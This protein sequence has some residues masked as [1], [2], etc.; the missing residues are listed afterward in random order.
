MLHPDRALA[1]R[2]ANT[3]LNIV[4]ANPPGGERWSWF[5][6]RYGVL[7][8]R[9][10]TGNFA[11][12][13]RLRVVDAPN[14]EQPPSG[15][16]NAGGFVIRNPAG[17]HQGD[18]NW[19]MY[20]IGAQG[21]SGYAREVKKT[22]GSRSG[23]YLN[24]QPFEGA[25]LLVCRVD[26]SFRF[27]HWADGA[28]QAERVIPDVTDIQARQWPEV[29]E[30]GATPIQFDLPGL[31][32]TLQMGLMTGAW[33]TAGANDMTRT[34]SFFDYVRV[35]QVAPQDFTDCPLAFANP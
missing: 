21:P 13:A 16:F 34:Q 8:Y 32:A 2:I 4:A 14:A 35:A 15:A 19:V 30:T 33:Q 17:T 28:W 1:V 3:R 6:D 23:L 27:W 10:V 7:V 20:N 25:A 11:V 24:P 9:P 18:E 5:E 29:D 22:G 31:P 26:D 12:S